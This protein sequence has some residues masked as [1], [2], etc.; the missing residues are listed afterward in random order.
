MCIGPCN[1]CACH[2]AS[3]PNGV[4]LDYRIYF[5]LKDFKFHFNAVAKI[6]IDSITLNRFK[7]GNSKEGDDTKCGAMIKACDDGKKCVNNICVDDKCDALGKCADTS[8]KCNDDDPRLC[9]AAD[10]EGGLKIPIYEGKEFPLFA[11]P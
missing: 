4:K 8:K 6:Q 1:W 5:G 3:W 10:T 7:L 2:T 9:V 11:L